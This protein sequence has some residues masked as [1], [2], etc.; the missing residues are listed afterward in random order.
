MHVPNVAI[1]AAG[2]LLVAD[3]TIPLAGSMP[4]TASAAATARPDAGTTESRI[5]DLINAQ[6]KRQGLRLLAY[7]PQLDRMA[8][9]QAENMA[10]FQKM[11]HTIPDAG[12]PTIGAR[13]KYVG[14]AYG[15]IAE[16]VA[17]GY[18]NAETVVDGW[19]NSSGHRRNILDREVVETGIGI[20]RSSAG[21]LYYCQVFGRQ[22]KPSSF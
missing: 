12:L 11:A 3:C 9:I 5:F 14:Y 17:L 15:R 1:A 2:I 22:L 4:S 6:R 13:A 19:M 8:K 18:P 10:H 20:A 7:N 21:G 16:N